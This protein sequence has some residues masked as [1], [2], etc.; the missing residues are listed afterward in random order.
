MSIF[1]DPFENWD[2]KCCKTIISE[3]FKKQKNSKKLIFSYLEYYWVHFCKGNYNI[4]CNISLQENMSLRSK[5]A[6]N[7]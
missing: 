2:F 1:M 5:M 3:I 4:C 7:F 6:K